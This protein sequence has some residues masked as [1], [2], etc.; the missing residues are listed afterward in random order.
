MLLS[1]G[2]RLGV[3]EIVAPLGAGGMGEVYRARDTKLSRSVAIKI[4]PDAFAADPER[5]ARFEREAKMLAA[6]NHPRITALHGM[7]EAGS[8]HFLVMELVEGETLAEALSAESSRRLDVDEALAI[9]RQIAEALEAAH[10]QGIVHRDL[11]PANIKRRPDGT[12]K[13]LDFGLAKAFEPSSGI[14]ADVTASPTITTPAMTH[15]GMILGTAAYMSPEQAK[16]RTADKRSDVWGF[17]CVLYEMLAGRRAFEGDDVSDTLATVLK[18]EPDWTALPS[19][20]PY[21]IRT[22][23]QSCLRKDRQERIGDFATVRFLLNQP[24]EVSSPEARS[25]PLPR[26][27]WKRAMPLLASLLIGAALATAVLWKWRATAPAATVTRFVITLPAGQQLQL[28]R[29]SV[30]ISPDGT[31]IVYAADGRLYTRMLSDLEP[32]T[33]PGAEPA[34]N[35]VFSPDG[36]SLAFWSDGMLKRISVSGGTPVTICQIG[37]APSGIVWTD[38]GIVFGQAGTGIMRASAIGGNP[39]AIVSLNPAEALGHGPQMLPDGDTLLFTLAERRVP[40]TA[41]PWENAHVVVQSLKTGARK[42]IVEHGTDARYVATGHVVYMVGGTL[43]G[44]PFDLR[45]LAVTG[46]AVPIVEGV[47]R[48]AAATTGSAHFAF[49]DS[50][51]LVYVPGP[52]SAAQTSLLLSDRQGASEA[53][54]LPPGLYMYPR[55]SPDGRYVAFETADRKEVQ[56]AIFELSGASAVRRLTFGGNNRYPTWSADG[57]HVAFQSDREGAPAVFRESADGGVAERLTTAEPGTSHVPES[58]SSTGDT[59]LFSVK[60]GLEFSLWTLDL[61]DRKTAPFRDV[62]SMVFPTNAAFSPDGRWVAYQI[63]ESGAGEAITFVEPFPPTGT[64]Y[65][66][67]RGGRPQ[68]SR[69]GTELFY[70]PNPGQF[71]AVAVRTRPSLTFASPVSLPRRFGLADPANARPYDIA[72][73]GRIIGSGMPPTAGGSPGSGQ[74]HVV[75]N[76]VEELKARVGK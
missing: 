17:G 6:L 3:Y 29:Q 13:V 60:K 72:P 21:G 27:V 23:I 38:E 66:V 7:E 19:D 53:L 40:E 30:N 11:K 2:S 64:K 63:G 28:A 52:V 71:L 25:R 22:L 33:I 18:G 67:G 46:G 45:K 34:I 68:W 36:Q 37:T 55:V 41:D 76:W 42:T 49:S 56:V 43:F 31:R 14:R 4:L 39:Q 15:L 12:I 58:W 70:V 24:S 47:S 16:G 48:V 9:G 50:G 57:H 26:P 74:M 69:D 62:K 10:E 8:R 54:K 35:P 20:L 44:A 65:Q 1:A 59:L 61:K 51:T 75:L 73:D 32:R 5:L